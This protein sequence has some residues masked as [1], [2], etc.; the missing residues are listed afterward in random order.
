MILGVPDVPNSFS[1]VHAK[2][3][4]YGMTVLASY[5]IKTS[6]EESEE[7]A[8]EDKISFNISQN[9]S[10]IGNIIDLVN[11]KLVGED[12]KYLKLPGVIYRYTGFLNKIYQ[13]VHN[14][15]GFDDSNIDYA[16]ELI[17][18]FS[19]PRPMVADKIYR[20]TGWRPIDRSDEIGETIKYYRHFKWD[21]FLGTNDSKRSKFG[22]LKL[23]NSVKSLSHKLA[24]Y[25]NEDPYSVVK[26]PETK[27]EMD[28]KTLH[29][30]LSKLKH[31]SAI[32]FTKDNVL[33]LASEYG[34]DIIKHIGDV[35]RFEFNDVFKNR[36][37]E[38]KFHSLI[39]FIK[40]FDSNNIEIYYNMVMLMVAI[41]KIESSRRLFS[42]LAQIIPRRN[43]GILIE[44][45]YGDIGIEIRTLNSNQIYISSVRE[46]VDK[47]SSAGGIQDR[48]N[49][50]KAM[51]KLDLVVGCMANRIIFDMSSENPLDAIVPNIGTGYVF[52][53]KTHMDI[54]Y[55]SLSKSSENRFVFTDGTEVKFIIKFEGGKLSVCDSKE[56]EYICSFKNEFGKKYIGKIKDITSDRIRVRE[57]STDMMRL[58]L[59]KALFPTWATKILKVFLK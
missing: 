26:I 28:L 21:K 50:F 6:V 43:I 35:F 27:L 18:K 57:I 40:Q 49:A 31:S 42:C 23:I 33:K 44:T 8:F 47:I 10:E 25:Q 55:N 15:V 19:K 37:I 38:N 45:V 11:S 24:N 22:N 30:I 3:I 29:I 54:F 7:D 4:V 51:R 5:D 1:L 32:S 34:V 58:L 2:D 9:P 17:D 59:D 14:W 13:K 52:T 39:N 41:S 48:I 36:D 53:H 16:L 56:Q 20:M 46:D 12:K